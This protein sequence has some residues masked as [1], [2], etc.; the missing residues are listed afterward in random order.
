MAL[1]IKTIEDYR[2]VYAKS[3]QDPENFWAEQA[4]AFTWR[5]PW[6]KVLEWNFREPDISNGF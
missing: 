2:E 5:K 6:D 4:A 1:R 3:V